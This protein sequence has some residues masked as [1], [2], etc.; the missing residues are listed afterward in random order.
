MAHLIVQGGSTLY[1]MDL[2]TGVATA[3]TLPTDVTLSTTRKPRFAVLNQWIVMAHSP[4]KNLAIDPEGTV[5]PL[6]LRA[7]THPPTIAAGA[8]TG[9]TG[10]YKYRDSFIVTNSDGDLLMESPLS[11]EG[12][13]FTLANT[14]ALLTDIAPSLDTISARRIYRTVA[15]GTA[16]FQVAD[17]D[18]N[19]LETIVDA[20]A[21]ATLSLLPA[22]PSILSS[23][24]GTLPGVRFKLLIEW[25]LRLWGVPDDP[26]LH[27]VVYASETNKV[28]AWPNTIPVGQAGADSQGIVA[29]AKRR[30]QL[31]I[32]KRNGVWQISGSASS[33]GIAVANIG[34]SQIGFDL[35][36][37][38]PDS[39]IAI[40]DKVYWLGEDGV[41]EWSDAGIRNITN[42]SVGPWFKSDT[43]FNRSR[44]ASAFAKYNKK[45]NSYEL[46]L[47][48]A[49]DSTENRWVSLSM[50]TGKWL[51]PHKTDAFTPSHS[52]HCMDSNGL[53]VVLVGGTDGV[54]YAGNSAN[55]R[56][57]ASTAIDFDTYGP[58]HHGEAPTIEHY[59]GELTMVSKVE[60]A[61]SLTVTPTVG[62]LDSS[63][64]AAITHA[65]TTGRERLRRLGTGKLMRVR[66][67]HN[68]VNQ[69]VSVM[70][71]EVPWHE[72]GQR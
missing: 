57:G 15:G 51:G 13:A 5:R 63:A 72:L 32:L 6:T 33:T 44:F 59:W 37:V 38:A 45:T 69:G 34:V 23:P 25:K 40:N 64:G 11:P 20:T 4:S 39:V 55:Y 35:G 62:W 61:G 31:G 24:P 10:A 43:Y 52:H 70:G 18:G 66:M 28:Y 41:Y 17:V 50:T 58:W 1:K 14:D 27:D 16:Y 71:Y 30:N 65:L 19:V 3:L 2:S 29:F 26:T 9:L 42:D 7:P 47:A 48:N 36:C 12:A 56:D 53:P 46:H 67:R 49:G 68:T 21:D 22:V 60:A 54:V 8:S